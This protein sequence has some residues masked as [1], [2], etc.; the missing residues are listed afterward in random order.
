M[1]RNLAT[2][3]A[4]AII[5]L[6]SAAVSAHAKAGGAGGASFGLGHAGS[7]SG[8]AGSTGGNSNGS[9]AMEAPPVSLR[10][11][12]P[13]AGRLPASRGFAPVGHSSGRDR[14]PFQRNLCPPR[15]CFCVRI[16]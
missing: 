3:G 15:P 16:V 14:D 4:C 1:M 12:S 7:A 9:A 13:P 6:G 11:N 8:H 10:A 5:L 2:I